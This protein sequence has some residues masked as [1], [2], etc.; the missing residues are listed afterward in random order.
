[1]GTLRTD[2]TTAAALSDHLLRRMLIT[3]ECTAS[4]DGYHV[5]KV[6]DGRC[7]LFFKRWLLDIHFVT[8][9]PESAVGVLFPR[10]RPSNSK[11]RKR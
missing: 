4:I 9:Y 2:N 8:H 6:V 5:V 10:S 7:A 11:V 1:M 3:Q